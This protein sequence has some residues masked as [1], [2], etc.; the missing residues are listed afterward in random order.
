M[1]LR[2]FI[3]L[4]AL[5]LLL[6][7]CTQGQESFS[8]EPGKGFG[9]KHMSDTSDSIQR[10]MNAASVAA[11][12]E[13]PGDAKVLPIT[14]STHLQTGV[15][16]IPEHYVKV[17]FA[18]YQDEWGNLHEECVI[19]TVMQTGQWVVPVIKPD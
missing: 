6:M 10:E 11:R 9:W 14:M 2:L 4:A 17:W 3:T 15:S 13:I 16:R 7:G 8:T 5:P 19:N 1:H 12:L 18:P